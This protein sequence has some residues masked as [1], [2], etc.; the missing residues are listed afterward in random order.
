M[1]KG[2]YSWKLPSSPEPKLVYKHHP[3]F[4]HYDQSLLT[5]KMRSYHVDSRL[6]Y[7]AASL[8]SKA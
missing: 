4:A 3:N 5:D 8:N 6:N 7:A 2:N 1:R